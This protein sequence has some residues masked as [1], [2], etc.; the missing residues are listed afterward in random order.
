MFYYRTFLTF[1]VCSRLTNNRF[2]DPSMGPVRFG[3][4]PAM[5]FTPARPVSLNKSFWIR[6][7]LYGSLFFM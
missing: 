3:S 5:N 2:M 1:F 7:E 4:Y 6:K